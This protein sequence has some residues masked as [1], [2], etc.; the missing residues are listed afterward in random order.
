MCPFRAFSPARTSFGAAGKGAGFT[1]RPWEAVTLAGVEARHYDGAQP[2]AP[3]PSSVESGDDRRLST[4]AT[5]PFTANGRSYRPPPRP[6]AVVCLD[7]CADEYLDAALA[8]GRMPCLARLAVEGWRGLARAALPSFTNTNNASIATGVPPAAH[9]ISGNFFLDPETG[10]EVMMNSARYLRAGTILAAAAR[11]GRRVAI[12]TAKDK[13]REILAHDLAGISFSAEKAREARRETHGI[14][15]LEEL[16]GMAAPP[17]Y[18]AGASLFV[19][20][21]GAALLERG[22]ADFLYLVVEENIFA[23]AEIPAGWGLLVRAADGLRFERP[24]VRLETAEEQR[25][26]LLE[27][28]ALAATRAV[29]RAAGVAGDQ[30]LVTRAS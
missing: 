5:T 9:G 15:G 23:E 21:A 30:F 26:S 13:L 6:V 3:I 20:R 28:I 18:S 25:R 12:A 4:P 10:E 8:R 29:S 19:L 11:A 16:A 1:P 7:G 17:I 14:D 2:A 22:R 24:P 27:S